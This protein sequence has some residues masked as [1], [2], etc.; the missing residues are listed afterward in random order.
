M[1]RYRMA[2]WFV[3]ASS[4]GHCLCARLGTDVPTDIVL[5]AASLSQL[6]ERLPP[7][8]VRSERTEADPPDVI[9]VWYQTDLA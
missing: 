8:L 2:E 6:R 4:A 3:T 7:G 1:S 5:T 9:E